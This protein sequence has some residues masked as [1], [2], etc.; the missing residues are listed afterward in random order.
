MI[1]LS[2]VSFRY[3]KK[4]AL[5]NN[6]NLSLVPGGIYGLLGKNGA[7][8]TTLLKIIAGIIF[9]QKG[10][11]QIFGFNPQKRNPRMLAD[12]FFLPEEF[13]LPAISIENYVRRFACFYPGFDQAALQ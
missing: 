11:I 9:V 3:N 2:D 4:A 7:G 8:K 5:F 13:G 12:L 10:T 6:L 1:T